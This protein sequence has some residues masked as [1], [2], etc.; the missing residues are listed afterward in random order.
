MK[1]IE[2][3]YYYPAKL[4]LAWAYHYNETHY[5]EKHAERYVEKMRQAIKEKQDSGEHKS[6]SQYIKTNPKTKAARIVID[7]VYFFRWVEKPNQKRGYTIFYRKMSA[8]NIGVIGVLQ[9]GADFPNCLSVNIDQV[10]PEIIR[11]IKKFS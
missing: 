4:Q 7:K 3:Y 10:I 9:D 8:G 5:G 6:F 11:D 2:P 1:D